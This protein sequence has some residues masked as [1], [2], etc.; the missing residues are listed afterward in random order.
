[1]RPEFL[2]QNRA[3]RIDPAMAKRLDWINSFPCGV[4]WL[5]SLPKGTRTHETYL[6]QFERFCNYL[7]KSP[8]ELL[9][10]HINGQRNF[11]QYG[12]PNNVIRDLLKQELP[13]VPLSKRF[14]YAPMGTKPNTLAEAE[15]AICGFFSANG[16]P[17]FAYQFALT[18]P[19][20]KPLPTVQDI[21]AMENAISNMT[22]QQHGSAQLFRLRDRAVLWFFASTGVRPETLSLMMWKDLIE[23][24]NLD[25]P[26]VFVIDPSRMKG[27]GASQKYVFT[28]QTA[29]LHKKAYDALTDYRNALQPQPQST[30]PIFKEIVER[31]TNRPNPII[32]RLSPNGFWQVFEAISLRTWGKSKRLSG[33]N[34]RH[35]LDTAFTIANIPFDDRYMLTGHAFKGIEKNYVGVDPSNPLADQ[36]QQDLLRKFITAIPYIT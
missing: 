19:T 15:K 18:K 1:M 32:E 11:L 5:D 25:A 7:K 23:T 31:F 27:K 4:R 36:K 12:T 35:F 24:K 29:F 10:L 8:E 30:E 21:Y 33:N 2:P 9:Q 3:S 17:I 13:K 16:L 22:F 6:F 14:N 26:I 20:R 34:F 28:Y